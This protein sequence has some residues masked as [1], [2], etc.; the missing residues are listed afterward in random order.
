M[1][2]STADDKTI[3]VWELGVPVQ[4][5]VCC[6]CP[7]IDSE[8]NCE[9]ARVRVR[10]WQRGGNAVVQSYIYGAANGICCK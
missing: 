10:K 2:A 8:T 1:F 3:R 6:W 5:K 4:V 9:H 7:S